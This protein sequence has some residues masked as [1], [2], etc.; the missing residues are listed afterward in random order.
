[1]TKIA[2]LYKGMLSD[3]SVF[4]DACGEP[5]EIVTGRAHVMPVLE[6]A[7][8]EMEVG[9]E[10]SLEI[11]AADAYGAYDEGAVQ[12]VPTYRIPGGDSLPVGG[13]ISWTSPRN[14]K[15]IPV[16]VRSIVNQVAELDFNHPLAGK[17]II[18]WVKLVSRDSQDS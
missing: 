4:D 7:L 15:P 5:H 3:G 2:F 8:L 6:R 14:A 12:R 10:R 18:Y 11:A 17:D 9:E 13:M 16:R 1:M